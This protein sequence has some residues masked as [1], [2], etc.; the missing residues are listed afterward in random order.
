MRTDIAIC[1]VLVISSAGFSGSARS[2]DKI[3]GTPYYSVMPSA[4]YKVLNA[5]L[6]AQRLHQSGTLVLNVL[7]DKMGG[8]EDVQI[9]KS[10]GYPLL[11]AA[12]LLEAQGWE[13]LHPQEGEKSDAWHQVTA[14]FPKTS[15]AAPVKVEAWPD[16][17]PLVTHITTAPGFTS[18][19]IDTRFPHMLDEYPVISRRMHQTGPMRVEFV[20]GTDGWVQNVRVVQSTGFPLLDAEGLISVGNWRYIPAMK[21]GVPVAVR[22]QAAFNFALN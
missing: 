22:M 15:D 20:V 19:S 7:V 8:V 4:G 11:D 2:A 16:E 14:E 17:L 12:A 10:S 13:F 3:E 9:A 6:I 18:P 5:P 21:D 1:I